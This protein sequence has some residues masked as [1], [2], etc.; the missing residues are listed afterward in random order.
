[1]TETVFEKNYIDYLKQVAALDV[2]LRLEM[3]GGRMDGEVAVIPFYGT[4]YRIA[5]DA[6]LDPAGSH[7]PYDVCVVLCRYLLLCPK[8]RPVE[9]NWVAYRDF[10]DAGPLTVFYRRS[11]EGLVSDH[12]AGKLA[13]LETAA[14]AA[15]GRPPL[16]D[17]PYD[18]CRRFEAL[19][20]MPVLLLFNDRDDEFPARCSVLFEARAEKFLDAESLAIVASWLAHDLVKRDREINP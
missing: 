19:P 10:R 13:G 18:L 12:F 17:F 20:R 9:D 1:M 5:Q 2:G 11:V 14:E 8:R 7:A 16:S 15:G 4:D 6:I 3:L